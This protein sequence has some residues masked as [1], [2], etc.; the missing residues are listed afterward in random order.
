MLYLSARPPS[1]PSNG[2]R[3]NSLLRPQVFFETSAGTQLPSAS[4]IA[5]SDHPGKR[6]LPSPITAKTEAKSHHALKK[7]FFEEKGQLRGAMAACSDLSGGDERRHSDFCFCF[8]SGFGPRS[9]LA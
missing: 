2:G 1:H 7:L 3:L 9:P 4:W 6:F 8:I 5:L